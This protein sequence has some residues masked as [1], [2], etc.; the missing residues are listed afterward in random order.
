MPCTLAE[1]PTEV[2]A[3][4]TSHLSPTDI[5]HS[6]FSIGSALLTSK[7]RQGGVIEL[8]VDPRDLI[9]GDLPERLNGQV[10]RPRLPSGLASRIQSLRL[11]SI[12]VMIDDFALISGLQPSLRHLSG[13]FLDVIAPS[14]A[15]ELDPIPPVSTHRQAVWNVSSSFPHLETLHLTKSQAKG[16]PLSDPVSAAR[17]L[18]GLPS[19][20]VS[21]R[22][23]A[24]FADFNYWPLLPPSLTELLGVVSNLPDRPLPNL[25]SLLTLELNTSGPPPTGTEAAMDAKWQRVFDLP[26]AVLPSKIAQLRLSTSN[27]A[28]LRVLALPSTLI[29][30]TVG[31]A[32][33]FQLS[34]RPDQLFG[35][36]PSTL[37]SL[38]MDR[39][40]FVTNGGQPNGSSNPVR[41]NLRVVSFFVHQD[42]EP[43]FYPS[44]MRYLPKVED[45]SL[46]LVDGHFFESVVPEFGIDATDLP[47]FPS[48]LRCLYATLRKNCFAASSD[49]FYPLGRFTQLQTLKLKHSQ[50][51]EDFSF[52]AIPK[53]LIYLNTGNYFPSTATIHLLPESLTDLRGCLLAPPDEFFGPLFTRSKSA[54]I[55]EFEIQKGLTTE[56]GL[57]CGY[58]SYI[59]R[60]IN[61]GGVAN[62]VLLES[63][64]NGPITVVLKSLSHLPSELS[65]LDL[66]RQSRTPCDWE[67]VTAAK[68]PH[69]TS[70]VTGHLHA[71]T[72][73]LET[74]E[75]L[76]HLEIKRYEQWESMLP[77]AN[78]PP[79]L[80]SLHGFV[81]RFIS[82]SL[83]LPVTLTDL[84]VHDPI[85]HDLLSLV[86]L[87]TFECRSAKH[88]LSKLTTSLP[89]NSLTS[90]SLTDPL[91]T[92]SEIVE[93]PSRFPALKTFKLLDVAEMPL[94]ALEHI[95][96]AF[97]PRISIITNRR[98]QIYTHPSR[99]ARL[100]GHTPGSIMLKHG[101]P[102]DWCHHAF[103]TAFPLFKWRATFSIPWNTPQVL[104][105]ADDT[106]WERLIRALEPAASVGMDLG[107]A[108]FNASRDEDATDNR[109]GAR[110]E[111]SISCWLELAPYLSPS[112]TELFLTKVSLPSGF[113][114]SL[115]RGLRTLRADTFQSPVLHLDDLPVSLTDMT[116]LGMS[117]GSA[118]LA[119]LPPGLTRLKFGRLQ[120]SKQTLDLQWPIGLMNLSFDIQGPA[121]IVR[122]LETLPSS[123]VTLKMPVS[124]ESAHVKYLP[125][126]LKYLGC[127]GVLDATLFN[128]AMIERN[129][130]RLEATPKLGDQNM[131]M[132]ID[133]LM[134]SYDAKMAQQSN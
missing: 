102:N 70:L 47:S 73:R 88:G 12:L 81:S 75:S 91:M 110:E 82:A 51:V 127:S 117:I 133:R 105:R 104:Q 58:F 18:L 53:S 86:N 65:S 17:F 101:N 87:R 48:T 123:L 54:K 14:I 85:D 11:R 26:N 35:L 22:L 66:S 10:S 19:T 112:Q 114:A 118:D 31:L 3:G 72:T 67:H 39:S 90:L 57:V 42:T 29:S 21:L 111:K 9:R 30:L 100:A 43:G 45:I 33:H 27:F 103:A 76:L 61:D 46:L 56:K 78:C 16:G 125:R 130:T 113:E 129:M 96:K 97:L 109:S 41:P 120:L 116:L 44:V 126:N 79:N 121:Y 131:S 36:L 107:T 13:P 2:L 15:L 64:I 5:L 74:F 55:P 108:G 69:L 49:G 89:S 7:L 128:Q 40:I 94:W 122:V 63:S 83:E 23:P 34:I 50:H 20:L 98:M 134:A 95:Y 6:L 93:L 77:D 37:E 106:D 80:T 1:V 99:L 24:G 8:N 119:R 4:I 68:L 52:A 60:R 71:T 38:E 62:R 32:P 92:L 28:D 132:A 84:R 124:F 59:M 115:P 25:A